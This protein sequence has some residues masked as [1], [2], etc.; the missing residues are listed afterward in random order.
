ME[1]IIKIYRSKLGP[2][3]FDSLE[4]YAKDFLGF[5]SDNSQLF[6]KEVQADYFRELIRSYFLQITRAALDECERIVKAQK[7]IADDKVVAVL[8]TH[9]QSW[10]EE[11]SNCKDIECVPQDIS[12]GLEKLYSAIIEKQIE[13]VFG[14]ARISE[15][16]KKPIKD[17]RR[18]DF[19]KRLLPRDR[20]FRNCSGRIWRS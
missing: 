6:P 13:S 19:F 1:T 20:K 9:I 16:S 2:K 18:Q 17:C 12:S 11:L 15:Q 10:C 14:N 5:L 4:G 7:S 8:E 3:K